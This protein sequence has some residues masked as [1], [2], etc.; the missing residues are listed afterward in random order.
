MTRTFCE[1]QAR[2]YQCD[3]DQYVCDSVAHI[4]RSPS[5][6]ELSF[7]DKW[8][9]LSFAYDWLPALRVSSSSRGFLPASGGEQVRDF[10][11]EVLRRYA[12]G[13]EQ[14]R[15]V[16]TWRQFRQSGQENNRHFR[17]ELFHP[18]RRLRPSPIWQPMI[19]DHQ[20]HTIAVKQLQASLAVRR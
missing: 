15:V 9:K 19:C 18:K 6:A 4:S 2:C 8:D 13:E 16:V 5:G 12:F 20:V 7:H 3:P 1:Q 11:Q 14:V 10:G 17:L